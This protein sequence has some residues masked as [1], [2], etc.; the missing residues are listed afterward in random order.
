ME[1]TGGPGEFGQIVIYVGYGVACVSSEKA[2]H[3]EREV[4]EETQKGR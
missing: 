1:K 2:E 3:G 4:G